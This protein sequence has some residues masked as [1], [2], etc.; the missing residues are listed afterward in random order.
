MANHQIPRAAQVTE[1]I[2]GVTDDG[3]AASTYVCRHTRRGHDTP[4]FYLVQFRW[5]GRRV[6]RLGVQAPSF[7]AGSAPSGRRAGRLR[8]EPAGSQLVSRSDANVRMM[9]W[10][11]VTA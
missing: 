7:G 10:L 6:D 2:H 1:T 4:E 11:I 9:S 8:Q 5:A 3:N